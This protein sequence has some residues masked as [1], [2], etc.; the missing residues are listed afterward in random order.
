M[1]TEPFIPTVD[2]RSGFLQLNALYQNTFKI[3]LE[4]NNQK[5]WIIRC[6]DQTGKKL[7]TLIPNTI[8]AYPTPI[9]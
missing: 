1:D 7:G 4:Y 9:A 6:Y 8:P 2:V 3:T 5:G